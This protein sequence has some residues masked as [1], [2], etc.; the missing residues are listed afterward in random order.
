MSDFPRRVLLG[1]GLVLCLPLLALAAPATQEDFSLGDAHAKVTVFEYAS[2][3][4]PHCARFNND[5]LPAFKA[6]YVDTGKVRYVFREFLTDPVAVSGA[7]FITAR[8]AGAD[9][10]FTVLDA[11]FRGQQHMYETGDVRANLISAGAA[12]GLSEQQVQACLSDQAAAKALDERVQRYVKDDH[13][14]GTPTF[15]IGD[16]R[17]VGEQTLETL[18]VAVDA[19]LA[20]AKHG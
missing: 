15:V 4:C 10:Y 7:A 17:L 9:N 3:S 1:L 18:S 14:E 13:V 5:V 19:A 20:K 16:Q 6:K 11:F 8:C 2:A 12:G